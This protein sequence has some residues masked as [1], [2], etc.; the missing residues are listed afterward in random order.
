MAPGPGVKTDAEIDAWIRK[1]AATANHPAATCVMG[2]GPDANRARAASYDAK[3]SW[4]IWKYDFNVTVGEDTLML[5][6]GCTILSLG[7]QEQPDGPPKPVLWVSCQKTM[8]L[9]ARE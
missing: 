3:P 6:F 5:P 4:T 8:T 9:M 2:S 7:V 1:V